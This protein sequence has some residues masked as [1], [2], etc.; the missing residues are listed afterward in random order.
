MKKGLVLLAGITLLALVVLPVGVV[1]TLYGVRDGQF[2]SALPGGIA[3]VVVDLPMDAG[4]EAGEGFVYSL[5]MV[6][7]PNM[8]WSDFSF[9]SFRKVEDN[10]TASIAINFDT[11][12]KKVGEC[13]SPYTLTLVIERMPKRVERVWSGGVCVSEWEDVDC[14]TGGIGDG[15]EDVMNALNDHTDT[16]DMQLDPKIIKAT[17]GEIKEFTLTVGGTEPAELKVSVSE[18]TIP[19]EPLTEEVS[20]SED[21]PYKTI[22]FSLRA[23]QEEGEYEF[24]IEGKTSGCSGSY[25]SKTVTGRISVSETPEE[26]T[27]FSVTMFPENIDSRNL[28]PVTLRYTVKNNLDESREFDISLEVEPVGASNTFEEETIEVG[29]KARET[30]SF[31]FTPAEERKMYRVTVTATSEGEESSFTSFVSTDE[32]VSDLLRER[33]DV[34]NDLSSSD[35]TTLGTEIMDWRGDYKTAGYEENMDGYS[36]LKETID[37]A[38]TDAQAEPTDDFD[39]DAYNDE[40]NDDS[41]GSGGIDMTFILVAAVMFLGLIGI[42]FLYRKL[43]SRSKEQ[44]EFQEVKI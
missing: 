6:P 10:N 14:V 26:E 1:A 5:E 12:G 30:S 16:F 39:W 38:R 40:F 17:P 15:P 18:G 22:Q 33:D 4:M 20:T 34:W 7:D 36:S 25:C 29:P 2:I 9:Q 41:E 23:P 42:Y 37:A 8:T 19:I 44:G 11:G 43:S 24:S 3:T 31:I 35:Q 27:G 28:N 13:S 21:E 32:M